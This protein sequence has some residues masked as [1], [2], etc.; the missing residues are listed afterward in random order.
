VPEAELVSFNDQE[1]LVDES[2]EIAT[3]GDRLDPL[4]TKAFAEDARR[5]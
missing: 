5:P 2:L 4:A 1:I 3:P